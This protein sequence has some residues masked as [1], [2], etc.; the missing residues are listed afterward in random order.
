MASFKDTKTAECLVRAFAGESQSHMRYT[1]YSNIARRQG[2]SYI[3]EVFM[4]IADSEVEHAKIFYK[5]LQ[6][7][8]LGDTEFKVDGF[9]TY[10]SISDETKDNLT[11]AL[12]AEAGESKE[13]YPEYANIAEAE[14]YIEIAEAFRLIARVEE[15]HEVRF[16]YLLDSMTKCSYFYVNEK[17]YCKCSNCGFVNENIQ[18]IEKK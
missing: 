6:N 2:Y 7:N 12:S 13:I 14:G 17:L 11:F 8:G 15:D 4:E 16:K 3:A 5:K 9:T 10:L 18:A 1:L